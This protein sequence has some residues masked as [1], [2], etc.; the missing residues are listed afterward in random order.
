MFQPPH[1]TT[2]HT[3]RCICT[4]PHSKTALRQQSVQPLRLAIDINK[5]RNSVTNY[6]QR[7]TS[8]S[9]PTPLKT[10]PQGISRFTATPLKTGPH[11][12]RCSTATV[13]NTVPHGIRCSTATPLKT[14]PLGISS[15]TATPLKTVRQFLYHP[16]SSA[17]IATHNILDRL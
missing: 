1:H 15:F 6:L 7:G 9:T 5:S 17:K 2:P 12:I 16:S 13:L 14:V 3:E 8:C 10:V 11:G 4:V